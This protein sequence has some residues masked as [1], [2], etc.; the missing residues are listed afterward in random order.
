V[1]GLVGG[2]LPATSTAT[3]FVTRAANNASPEAFTNIGA[4]FFEEGLVVGGM[5]QSVHSA[6]VLGVA[7]AITIA[8]MLW[9]LIGTLRF[10]KSLWAQGNSA[11]LAGLLSKAMQMD[12]DGLGL[13]TYRATW[14][15]GYSWLWVF[16]GLGSTVVVVLLASI[17]RWCS[18]RRD[19][20]ELARIRVQK[21]PCH[22]K[23]TR[24]AAGHPDVSA[25]IV[26]GRRVWPLFFLLHSTVGE[27]SRPLPLYCRYD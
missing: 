6:V 8:R 22:A 18:D 25:G 20:R 23:L 1:V 21:T 16:A 17:W 11:R 2:C 13:V 9:L 24:T 7:L 15:A 5:W 12:R 4:S 3:K 14:G 27:R 26:K 19:L 10:L